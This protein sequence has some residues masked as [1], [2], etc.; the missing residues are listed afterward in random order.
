MTHDAFIINTIIRKG[1]NQYAKKE[2]SVKCKIEYIDKSTIIPGNP[3]I[4]S[5]NGLII[6]DKYEDAEFFL[7]QYG[8]IENYMIAMGLAVTK[9]K[10]NKQIEEL[11][12][13]ASNDKRSMVHVFTLM[14]GT[15]IF[16]IFADNLI[17]CAKEGT[18]GTETLK[19]LFKILGIGIIGVGG[20]IGTYLL[21]KK[22]TQYIEEKNKKKK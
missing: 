3:I 19:R 9:Q 21:Y 13:R 17:K 20:V 8:S 12:K 6:F 11:N 16:S 5:Y 22:Y 7:K 1:T 14:G 18:D 4:F 10:Q 2:T 15:S